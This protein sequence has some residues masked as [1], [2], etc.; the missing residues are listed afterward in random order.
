[1]ISTDFFSDPYLE[2]LFRREARNAN[3]VISG[4]TTRC[5]DPVK[6]KAAFDNVTALYTTYDRAAA[7][8]MFAGGSSYDE[9]LSIWEAIE[10]DFGVFS[11]MNDQEDNQAIIEIL[12]SR[13]IHRGNRAHFLENPVYRFDADLFDLDD[14][15]GP[16]DCIVWDNFKNELKHGNRFFPANFLDFKKMKNIFRYRTRSISSGEIY[17]RARISNS[18][19]PTAEMG[20]PPAAYATEGR[21]NP[22]GISYL[23]LGS[24]GDSCKREIKINSGG[25]T[26]GKFEVTSRLKIVDLRNHYIVSP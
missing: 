10:N 18:Q 14:P 16:R 22:K 9:G 17:Y 4:H 25:Y 7:P 1:M 21:A 6:I 13:P 15:D 3:C 2:R 23:Y 5:I 19:L 26:L 20:P 8:A 24:N 11:P 12:Y